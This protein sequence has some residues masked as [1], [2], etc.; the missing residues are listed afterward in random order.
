MG[1]RRLFAFLLL[2]VFFLSFASASC[3]EIKAR[4]SGD[5]MY[6]AIK[7]NSIIKL[8]T[9][10][11]IEDLKVGD[12]IKFD[13][14]GFFFAYENYLHRITKIGHDKKGWYART[15]GDNNFF[16]DLVK[17]RENDVSCKM[18]KIN[19]ETNG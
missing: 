3:E 11:N 2:G 5:S 9:I 13:Y 4:S 14:Y 1:G 8:E 10:N 16:R 7:E 6:P 12:I 19:G 18:S 17:L 15:K